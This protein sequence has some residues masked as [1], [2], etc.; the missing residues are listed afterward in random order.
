M[1]E[2][3]PAPNPAERV[4]EGLNMDHLVVGTMH[5][6]RFKDSVKHFHDG[7]SSLGLEIPEL[8]SEGQPLKVYMTSGKESG[9]NTLIVSDP[10][11]QELGYASMQNVSRRLSGKGLTRDKIINSPDSVVA[12]DEEI[13]SLGGLLGREDLRVNQQHQALRIRKAMPISR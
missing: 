2:T 13:A 3:F 1:T 6:I 9:N 4:T 11:V 12:S 5:D 10:E 7:S 8:G